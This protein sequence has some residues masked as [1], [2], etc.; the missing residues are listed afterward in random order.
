MLYETNRELISEIT[1]RMLNKSNQVS[2]ETGFIQIDHL[3]GGFEGGQ[4][5]VMG[6]R[7]AMGKTTFACS[8][9]DNVCINGGKKCVYMS[10]EYSKEALV[11]RL[12][13]VHGR[14]KCNDLDLDRISNSA[15]DIVDAPL[16]IDDTPA[17]DVE[18]MYKKCREISKTGPIEYVIVDYIQLVGHSRSQHSSLIKVQEE[19]LRRLKEMAVELNCVVFVLSQ[20]NRSAER[21]KKHFP[22]VADFPSHDALDMYADIILL[23]YRAHYYYT[24]EDEGLST[25]FV[26][27]SKAK[28]GLGTTI[29]F[30][31]EVPCFEEDL[32]RTD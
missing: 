9:V 2:K 17:L 11:D 14:I 29:R 15:S 16:W 26:A 32:W 18:D 20:L 13:H 25:V 7:P 28:C 3:T 4:L 8:L 23:L 12:I 19:V 5:V 30:C 24:K 10:C 22:I 1:D 6:G 31:P 27:R 21:R